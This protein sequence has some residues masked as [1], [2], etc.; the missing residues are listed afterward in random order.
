MHKLSHTFV[1]NNNRDE[2]LRMSFLGAGTRVKRQKIRIIFGV[3]VNVAV[4][5]RFS[6]SGTGNLAI[7]H[8]I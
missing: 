3:C 1:K 6:I 7:R 8:C 4:I 2:T 5:T